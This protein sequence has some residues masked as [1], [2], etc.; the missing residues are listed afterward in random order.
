MTFR[1]LGQAAAAAAG[2]AL[3]LS[4]APAFASSATAPSPTTTLPPVTLAAAKAAALSGI[5]ARLHWIA[6]NRW[7][8]ATDQHVPAAD[9]AALLPGL[10]ADETAL[11]ADRAAV[12]HGTTTAA[13]AH[14]MA[15]VDTLRVFEFALPRVGLV[16]RADD[17]NAVASWVTGYEHGY[18]TGI[19]AAKK[20]GRNVAAAQAAYTDYVA[21]VAAA[22]TA[23]SAVR[24]SAL[25]LTLAGYPANASALTADTAALAAAEH[26]LAVAGHDVAVMVA[27]MP[28]R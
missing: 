20:A 17:A 27:V 18:A 4:A 28:R 5:D 8:V 13:I 9:K 22:R 15:A 12:A 21:K 25:S 6:V 7:Y 11:G 1:R 14:D 24:T 23:T 16:G 3:V 19:A 10:R 2:A 26:D